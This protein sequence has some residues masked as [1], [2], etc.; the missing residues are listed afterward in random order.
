MSFIG[1]GIKK[2]MRFVYLHEAMVGV[3]MF[4]LSLVLLFVFKYNGGF[5][6]WKSLVIGVNWV[7]VA[8]IL[9]FVHHKLYKKSYFPITRTRFKEFLRITVISVIFCVV[10]DLFGAFFTRLWY[11]P[12]FNFVQYALL[13]PIGFGIYTFSLFALYEIIKKKIDHNAP[14]GRLS[15][16]QERLYKI[17]MKAYFFISIIGFF[18]LG[19]WVT[20]AMNGV[21]ISMFE[22]NSSYN[23][24]Q[25]WWIMIVV[26][27]LLFL[28]FEAYCFALGKET[29]TRDIIRGNVI[30][31]I[32]II[33]AN[34]LGIVIFE[35]INAPFQIWIFDNWFLNDM[36]LFTL[37][38]FAILSWPF[39][40]LA[41][42]AMYRAVLPTNQENIW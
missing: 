12:F 23:I 36:K 31:I 4:L 22:I 39:Q 40:F 9:D 35:L 28:V 34:I 13:A 16:N 19:I 17:L 2:T 8:L 18:L 11:Y 25:P 6:F 27:F 10:L 30:P 15:N 42:L 38:L 3:L 29:L 32:S 21:S 14:K 7:A 33:L 5:S 37:P 1:K 41:F 20:K 24:T 26:L